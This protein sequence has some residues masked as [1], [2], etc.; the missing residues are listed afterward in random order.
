MALAAELIHFVTM[1][2]DAAMI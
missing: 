2:P 1:H